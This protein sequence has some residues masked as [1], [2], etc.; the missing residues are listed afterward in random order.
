M[1]SSIKFFVLLFTI[2]LFV[3]CTD[4][5]DDTP[6][7]I[8]NGTETPGKEDVI[9]DDSSLPLNE[10]QVLADI[11]TEIKTDLEV[12]LPESLGLKE[13]DYLTATITS[14][15][16]SYYV[17]F[18]KNDQPMQLNDPQLLSDNNPAMKILKLEAKRYESKD[19]AAEEIAFQD[20]SQLGGEE[21]DLGRDIKGYRDAG[22]GSSFISW[23]EGRWGLTS[24][25]LT[26]EPDKGEALAKEAVDFLENI[27]LPI[28]KEYGTIHLDTEEN[29][30][31]A[32]LQNEEVVYTFSEV[33]D[34][35]DM[36]SFLSLFE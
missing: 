26:S 1:K 9:P 10:E 12:R 20:F 16:D 27:M 21:M 24:R 7:P 35:M 19:K 5:K 30:N 2:L 6:P 13:G 15:A 22:A 18:Y 14:N 23:N 32:K 33:K 17:V 34:P 28:P 8:D 29:G 36:L 4:V 31:L 3:G 11:K 25:T